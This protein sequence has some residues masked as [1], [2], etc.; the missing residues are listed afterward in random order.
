MEIRERWLCPQQGMRSTMP[1]VHNASQVLR[2]P[3]L[4]R[5]VSHSL[6]NVTQVN[7]AV[8]CV[9][10]LVSALG[11]VENALVLWVVGFRVR[12]TVASVWVLN[13]S[14]SDLLTT[15]TLPLF[16]FYLYSSHSWEL[17]E[18]LCV[19]QSAVFFLNLFISAFLLA[20]IS[21]DRCLLVARPIWSQNR[22]CVRTA[23]AVCGLGWLWAAANT[24]PYLPFRV[25]TERRDGRKLCYHNFALYSDPAWLER[26]C[27]LRQDATAISKFTLAFLVPLAVIAG[28]YVCLSRSLLLRRRSLTGGS[29]NRISSCSSASSS[30]LSRSFAKM[31]AAII[32]AFV[33]CWSPYHAFCLLEM[34]SHDWPLGSTLVE[35]GLPIATTVSFLNAILNPMLY[36]FSCPH[37]SVRIRQ[38]L[39]ALLEGL[40]EEGE[41]GGRR[42]LGSLSG[43]SQS[44]RKRRDTPALIPQHAVFLSHSSTASYQLNYCAAESQESKM[45]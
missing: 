35:V 1:E 41:G 42:K 14:L 8:V 17:G 25:V 20:V 28:S 27:R 4:E 23:W 9:H 10:G 45:L 6:N 11:I 3:M 32:A 12:R 24:L 33:V 2:C 43:S 5:M 13:L 16:T 37:F 44:Q 22:R 39:G 15:L 30:P 40:L 19:A 38:S 18:P 7:L 26:D 21:L 29:R 34:A 36:A 31:M